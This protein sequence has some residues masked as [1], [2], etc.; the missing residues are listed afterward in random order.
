[1]SYL[2]T[3]N[4]YWQNLPNI[5]TEM[6]Q[7]LPKG[8]KRLDDRCGIL[9]NELYG[10]LPDSLTFL[11][12]CATP[13][14]PAGLHHLS[15]LTSLT[16]LDVNE[17]SALDAD[18]DDANG[19]NPISYLPKS[20][21]T[22]RARSWGAHCEGLA[23]LPQDLKFLQVGELTCTY[24]EITNNPQP[25]YALNTFHVVWNG[26]KSKIQTSLI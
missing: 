17:T 25:T 23:A 8:L 11:N 20:L 14:T 18:R 1:M 9:D 15:R 3:G 13:L 24:P 26:L 5:T 12:L 7:S 4:Q 2:G 22:L 10:L 19:F 21:K 16:F 6:I